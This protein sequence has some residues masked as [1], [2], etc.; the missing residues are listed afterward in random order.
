[1]ES[2]ISFVNGLIPQV[3]DAMSSRKLVE[4]MFEEGYYMSQTTAARALRM[5]AESAIKH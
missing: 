3:R 4:S 5:V 1:M 2:A